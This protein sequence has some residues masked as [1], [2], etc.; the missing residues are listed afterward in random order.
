MNK[1]KNNGDKTIKHKNITSKLGVTDK[2]NHNVF[3]LEWPSD[4]T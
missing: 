2:N 4:A 3:Y 1:L